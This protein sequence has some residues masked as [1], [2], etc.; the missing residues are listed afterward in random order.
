VLGVVQN[1]VNVAGDP[2]EG[3]RFCRVVTGADP[4]SRC[5]RA[6]GQ[7]ITTLVNGDVQ[8]GEAC[9]AAEPEYVAICRSGAG[10]ASSAGTDDV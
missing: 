4:K 3:L 5:Y 8:R 2:G 6:V 1:L 7:M 10:V 9:Q